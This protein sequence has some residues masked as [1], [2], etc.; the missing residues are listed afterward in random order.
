[1]GLVLKGD[2]EGPG[3]DEDREEREKKENIHGLDL[4]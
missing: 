4:D 1:M 3:W 2:D